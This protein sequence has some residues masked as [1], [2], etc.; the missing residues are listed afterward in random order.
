M[1]RVAKSN[2]VKSHAMHA[3][4]PCVF[5]ITCPSPSSLPH[6]SLSQP[7]IPVHSIPFHSFPFAILYHV[8]SN[9]SPRL[10]TPDSRLQARSPQSQVISQELQPWPIVIMALT[11]L[12]LWL[13]VLPYLHLPVK[14]IWSIS[15]SGRTNGRISGCLLASR[16][17]WP[18]EELKVKDPSLPPSQHYGILPT[19]SCSFHLHFLFRRRL[20]SRHVRIC[21]PAL[22]VMSGKVSDL[23]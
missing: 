6:L 20:C 2:A 13:M 17:C 19:L 16:S 5:A 12:D 7:S 8:Y 10:K 4:M 18:P 1:L 3:Y 21:T 15:S 11:S 14:K 22:I 23:R 9:S